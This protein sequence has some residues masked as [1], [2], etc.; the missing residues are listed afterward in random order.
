[1]HVFRSNFNI[2]IVGDDRSLWAMGMGEHDRNMNS[3]P[4]RVQTDF[5]T[6]EGHRRLV[7]LGSVDEVDT[8]Y[9]RLPEDSFLRKGYNRVTL[10]LP[11]ERRTIDGG[12][13][14]VSSSTIC[15]SYEV[16]IHR[17]EAYILQLAIESFSF[18]NPKQRPQDF[19]IRDYSGGW[20]HSLLSLQSK[21]D[22]TV[23]SS[24]A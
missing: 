1:M 9:M 20:Q 2:I 21:S 14:S 16:V 4:L 10:I 17:D 5:H 12:T 24:F 18:L 8:V 19:I 13:L 23:C 15:A 22:M 6:E 11:S 3:I 7:D